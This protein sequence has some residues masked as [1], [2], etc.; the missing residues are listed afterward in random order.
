MEIARSVFDSSGPATKIPVEIMTDS[1]FSG[2]PISKEK[3][4]GVGMGNYLAGQVPI[5]S[6]ANNVLE[7][8]MNTMKPKETRAGNEEGRD[9]QALIN[10]LTALGIRGS[11]GGTELTAE[12]EARDRARLAKE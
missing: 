6:A 12:F 8:D 7:F 11:G 2:A 1:T 3:P 9:M 4:G 10:Y 5:V